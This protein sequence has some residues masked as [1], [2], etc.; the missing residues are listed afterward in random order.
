M[1][2]KLDD[3]RG[4]GEQ[5]NGGTLVWNCE[6][7]GTGAVVS[8]QRAGNAA[9]A[10]FCCYGVCERRKREKKRSVCV[11][12]VSFRVHAIIREGGESL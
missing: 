7:S 12:V 8:V 4:R 10:P 5:K 2:L 3:W 6:T 11:Y 9:G 1:S